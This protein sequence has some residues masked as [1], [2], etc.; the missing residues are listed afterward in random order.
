MARNLK[1]GKKGND[2]KQLQR[3]LQAVGYYLG[4]KIDGKFGKYTDIAVRAFQKANKL[5]VDGIVGPKTR[6]AL[7]AKKKQ[8]AAKKKTVVKV[9]VVPY[10]PMRVETGRWHGQT[11][12]VGA[13]RIYSFQD[14]TVKGTS[15]LDTS[16]KEKPSGYVKRKGANPLEV[17]FKICLNA[18]GGYPDVRGTALSWVM[19]AGWGD[20]DYFYVGGKKL[21]PCMLMLTEASIKDVQVNHGNQW[22]RATVSVTMKQCE[23]N[24]HDKNVAWVAS[25]YPG[26]SKSSK[27]STKTTAK[28]SGSKKKTSTKSKVKA[29]TASIR[30]IQKKAKKAS[31]KKRKTVSVKKSKTKKRR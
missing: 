3:D 31:S 4:G 5:T 24:T 9:A 30:K 14:L 1:K 18:F 6:A 19:W 11:F 8:K 25:L 10:N 7:A 16:A 23:K 28:S 2:V 17:T 22:T 13:G 15:E 12:S 27:S 21:L 26:S 20:K 29:G